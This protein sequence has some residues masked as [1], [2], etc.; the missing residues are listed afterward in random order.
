MLFR[1]HD[2]KAHG[3]TNGTSWKSWKLPGANPRCYAVYVDERDKVWLSDFGANSVLRFNPENERFESW[4][5][6]REAASVRQ[7]LGRAGE[8]WF[9]ESGTET[10]S[11]IRHA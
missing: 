11:V 3:Q 10:I 8:V 2:P 6:P 5:F 4:P 7:I 9:P 1:S